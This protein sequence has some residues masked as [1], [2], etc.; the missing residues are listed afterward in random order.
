MTFFL[1]MSSK[2]NDDR[3]DFQTKF[4]I[5]GDIFSNDI[6]NVIVS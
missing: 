4:R 3:I 5:N 6:L 1:K 2:L